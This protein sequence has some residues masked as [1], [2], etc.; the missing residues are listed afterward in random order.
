[1]R[2]V[3]QNGQQKEKCLRI[4]NGLLLNSF[5]SFLLIKTL[6]KRGIQ[7]TQDQ[8]KPLIKKLKAVRKRHPDWV[9]LEAEEA[10]GGKIKIIL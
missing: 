2:I 6:N 5:F 10:S 8:M 9:V 4:P 3:L 1:M 7:L